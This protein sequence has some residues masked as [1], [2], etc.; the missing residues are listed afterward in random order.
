MRRILFLC[1]GN[2]Y[3]S[4][5]AEEYFNHQAGSRLDWRAQ[6]RALAR[7]LTSTGNLGPISPHALA[8]LARRGITPAAAE[9]WP[10]R[11]ASVDFDSFERVIALS[12]R[13][14]APMLALQFPEA[15]ELVEYFEIG[16]IDVEHPAVAIARLADCID[17]LLSGLA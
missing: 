16:D 13:E 1:T 9:R 2:Y 10:R 7:D 8:E 11:V 17:A 14:H 3:R 4:R 12:R 6:S 15:I 5:F